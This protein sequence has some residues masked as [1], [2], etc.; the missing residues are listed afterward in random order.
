M[1]DQ[2]PTGPLEL[3]AKMEYAEHEKTYRL[4]VQLAKWS[5]IVCVALLAA[6]A[7]GFFAGGGFFSSLLLFIILVG[8]GGY[9]LRDM[10]AHIT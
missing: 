5:T 2:T 1:A 4:F 10:P 7:F 6:M 3:G 9:V 8:G